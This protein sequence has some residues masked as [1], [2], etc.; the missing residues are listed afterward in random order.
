MPIDYDRRLVELRKSRIMPK[1]TKKP[2][3]TSM[4]AFI[5]VLLI[6]LIPHWVGWTA[7][8]LTIIAII[9]GLSSKRQE[10]EAKF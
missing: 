1:D 8:F 3:K 5:L 4:F 2:K 7:L 9:Y 6:I 10:A